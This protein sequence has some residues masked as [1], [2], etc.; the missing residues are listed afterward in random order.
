MSRWLAT[1]L[2][3]ST[4][5]GHFA[6][7]AARAQEDA[8]RVVVVRA[9]QARLAQYSDLACARPLLETQDLVEA[10]Q[11][12]ADKAGQR[13]DN[14]YDAMMSAPLGHGLVDLYGGQM[15]RAEREQ[16]KADQQAANFAQQLPDA[17]AQAGA[18]LE[19]HAG[20]TGGD[21]GCPRRPRKAQPNRRTVSEFPARGSR[22]SALNLRRDEELRGYAACQHWPNATPRCSRRRSASRAEGN[23][24][25]AQR[26]RRQ[27]RGWAATGP[28]WQDL[29]SHQRSPPGNP[30]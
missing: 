17:W 14:A 11:G 1:L 12:S 19:G 4:V 2:A 10:W 30:T 24:Q 18:C 25:A 6:A 8:D 21:S 26:S 22:H 15:R 29:G 27:A 9:L 16:S 5:L 7:P 23:A 20:T 3:L 28:H 13:R